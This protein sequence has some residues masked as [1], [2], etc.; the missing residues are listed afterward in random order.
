MKD[1]TNRS[2]HSTNRSLPI[3][4]NATGIGLPKTKSLSALTVTNA[5]W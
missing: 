4:P 2:V 3:E 1:S 5:N